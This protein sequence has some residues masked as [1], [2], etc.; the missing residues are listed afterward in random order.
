MPVKYE[1]EPR[2]CSFYDTNYKEK[3]CRERKRK[4]KV[5]E[6]HFPAIYFLWLE[7]KEPFKSFKSNYLLIFL[8]VVDASIQ[9]T[10]SV[11][12]LGLIVS[13]S[14]ELSRRR[15]DKI[16]LV[17]RTHAKDDPKKGPH[18]IRLYDGVDE[19]V[20]ILGSLEKCVFLALALFSSI[21]F[22][23]LCSEAIFQIQLLAI[24]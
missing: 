5:L 9:L 11:V 21:I 4:R 17:C 18:N 13:S 2:S 7:T 19:D 8:W 15:A 24:P 10:K 16:V 23:C 3:D 20:L 1:N 14:I 6:Y 12:R 22:I